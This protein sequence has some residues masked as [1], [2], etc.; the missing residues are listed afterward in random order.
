M[1]LQVQSSTHVY[2]KRLSDNQYCK[3]NRR[4]IF[5]PTYAISAISKHGTPNHSL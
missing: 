1:T 2:N 5:T 3:A 4:T